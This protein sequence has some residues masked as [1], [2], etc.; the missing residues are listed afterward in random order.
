MLTS[1]AFAN[2]SPIKTSSTANIT[3]SL[4]PI[5]REDNF[6]IACR[7]LFAKQVVDALTVNFLPS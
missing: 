6:L 2:P 1:F 5:N 4:P 7:S 3:D